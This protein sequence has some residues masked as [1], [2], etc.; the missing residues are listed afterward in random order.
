MA[1]A[2]KS[3]GK[4]GSRAK[5]PMKKSNARSAKK[6]AKPAKAAKRGPQKA[7]KKSVAK[8]AAP[9]K[10]APKKAAKRAPAKKRTPASSSSENSNPL[11]RVARVAKEIAHQT[12]VA[13]SEGVDKVKE[14]SESIVD[15]VTS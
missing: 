14:V 10:M 15:R 3:R 9:K 7:A 5:K 1:T 12:T 11:S 13:V 8:K 6:A 2:K 4:A